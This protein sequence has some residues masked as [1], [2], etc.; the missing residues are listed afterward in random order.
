MEDQKRRI[1]ES[2]GMQRSHIAAGIFVG[3]LLGGCAATGSSNPART[4]SLP[5]NFA[6]MDA[7]KVEYVTTDISDP[8]MA[9]ALGVNL[10]PRLAQAIAAPGRP[11]LVERVY[12]FVDD[13]Q[14]TVF[15]SAPTPS[16]PKNSEKSYSP[17]WRMVLV[18]WKQPP[19][20]REL[21]SEEEIFRAEDAGDLSLE[22]T[23]IVVNCPITRSIGG[24]AIRGAK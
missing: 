15:Q 6:W 5:L 1:R 3:L 8:T 9:Q 10:V 11:S 13:S 19:R 16:G 24:E 18:R 20:A 23:N 4:V 17:L 2:R 21:K 7:H 12:K 14:I 22:V